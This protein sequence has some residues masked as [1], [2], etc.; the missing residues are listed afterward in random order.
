M[1]VAAAAYLLS[2]AVAFRYSPTGVL[3]VSFDM[4]VLSFSK[5]GALTKHDLYHHH[6]AATPVTALIIASVSFTDRASLFWIKPCIARHPGVVLSNDLRQRELS[7]LG[8]STG[9]TSIIESRNRHRKP[10]CRGG[11]LKP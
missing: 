7:D 4:K 2:S 3:P 8:P 11:F 10:H 6:A 9:I 5:S 1:A